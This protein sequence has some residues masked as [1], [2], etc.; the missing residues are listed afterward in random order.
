[1]LSVGGRFCVTGLTRF[2]ASSQPAKLRCCTLRRTR[3]R[4][5]FHLRSRL[6]AGH[7]PHHATPSAT[8]PAT[9]RATPRAYPTVCHFRF[10]LA[11]VATPFPTRCTYV[12]GTPLD[13]TS[14]FHTPFPHT[15]QVC[16]RRFNYTPPTPPHPHHHYPYTVGSTFTLTHYYHVLVWFH[17][18]HTRIHTPM[19]LCRLPFTGTFATTF[20]LPT[21]IYLHRACSTLWFVYCGCWIPLFTVTFWLVL[22][23]HCLHYVV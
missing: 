21:F 13:P 4:L 22:L 20:G 9:A 23:P 1:M 11:L 18:M 16:S 15:V 17:C 8:A 5:P 10:T 7:L 3:T 2:V 6:P 19:P 14:P 12:V